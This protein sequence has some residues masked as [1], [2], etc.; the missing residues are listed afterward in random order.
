MNSKI[1]ITVLAGIG[2][3]ALVGTMWW[4]FLSKP[5]Q[6][7][8]AAT[9]MGTF[10]TAG[11]A[12]SP[13]SAADSTQTNVG[14]PLNPNTPATPGLAPSI[15][16]GT[17]IITRTNGGTV[18]TYVITS[19]T[20]ANSSAPAGSFTM[21]SVQGPEG[22]AG[23]IYQLTASNSPTNA[24]LYAITQIGTNQGPAGT[25][26]VYTIAAQQSANVPQSTAQILY[27]KAS[28]T[29]GGVS[30]GGT[31]VPGVDWFVAPA[32]D[33]PFTTGTVQATRFNQNN[34]TTPKPS[35]GTKTASLQSAVGKVLG[36]S[37]DNTAAVVLAQISV[38]QV[39]PPTPAP[40]VGV[41]PTP[42]PTATQTFQ[43]TTSGTAFNP[44]AANQLIVTAPNGSLLPNLGGSMNGAYSNGGGGGLGSL[45]GAAAIGLG[46]G[47][48][49]CLAVQL[50]SL[51]FAF[52]PVVAVQVNN[53]DQN[54]E[55]FWSCVARNAAKLLIQKLTTDIVDYINNDFNGAPSFVTNPTQFFTNI[56]DRTAGAFLQSSALSFLCSPF[57]LQIKVAIAQS[58]ANR[59]NAQSCSL[60]KVTTNINNFMN[61]NFSAG[62]W[63]G[64]LSM[65]TE[66]INNPY[67][68]FVS[69]S[70]QFNNSI[71]S[72]QASQKLDLLQGN[73]FLNVKEQ[74]NCKPAA[75]GDTTTEGQE[76][77][78]TPDGAG[79]FTYQVC[80]IVNSTPGTIIQHSIEKTTDQSFDSLNLAKSFDEVINALVTR[81]MTN[82]VQGLAG[83]SGQNGYAS[84]YYT[85]AQ[86][87]AQNAG[88]ALTAQMYASIN[89]IGQ[90]VTTQQG[91]ISDIQN[92][93]AQLNQAFNCWSALGSA[94]AQD[95]AGAGVVALSQTN[96]AQATTTF[97]ALDSQIAAYNN[98]I[99]AANAA[100]SRV[101]QL[102]SRALSAASAADITSVTNDYNTA[103]A[104]GQILTQADLT[105]A[106]QNRATLQAQLA[107]IN[108]QSAAS[109]N[110]CHATTP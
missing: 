39:T 44:T 24:G 80:D 95:P 89:I 30:G 91:A 75:Q 110:Q 74:R 32:I 35:T 92:A 25:V 10:G 96:A 84:N 62:G 106:Q 58:Y 67:G 50:I 51:P 60:S 40:P 78:S 37:T 107:T 20:D 8:A 42:T 73:G 23:G 57:Q 97:A 87:A 4:W 28:T 18:G 103:V 69:G 1:V 38:P 86:Q 61:G 104:S 100:V 56:A 63:G 66:P 6:A 12:S 49:G 55:S 102:Q 33:Q 71:Q 83:L 2:V 76:W 72:K 11:D 21:T 5:N 65:T 79:G 19:A 26:A 81:L 3:A 27:G 109:L 90:Y 52:V 68:A 22:V 98:S 34:S 101:T 36:A 99:T 47:A 93:E 53:P 70:I 29:T 88:Q 41:T 46:A 43:P 31:P 105:T 17:Y 45:I 59:N 13:I 82:A 94:A 48:L 54:S 14:T 9:S 15:V 108:A 16:P 77:S 85:P 64:M 7:P